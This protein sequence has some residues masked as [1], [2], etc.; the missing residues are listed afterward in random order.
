MDPETIAMGD[1]LFKLQCLIKTTEIQH[2][3]QCKL[4]RKLFFALATNNAEIILYYKR[5]SSCLP[6]VKK[7]P[8]FQGLHKQIAAFC[9]DSSGTWLLCVTLDGSLYVLPALTLVGENCIIDK[10]WKTDDA[11]YISFV[12]SQISHFRPI[13][14]IWWR[15]TKISEDIGIIGTECGAIIFINLSNGQ[16]LGITYI[17]ES[18]SNLHLC[19]NEYNEIVSLL[20]TSKFQQQWRLSLEH[21]SFNLLHNVE[22]EKPY[23]ELNLSGASHYNVEDSVPNKSKLKELKQ[24]SVEK[25][26]I[27]KQKIIDTKNQTLKESLQYHDAARNKE[28]DNGIPVNSEISQCKLGF[29]SPE[30]ISKDTFLSLQYDRENR[31]LYTC[32]H[33]VTNYITVHGPNL[34]MVPLSMHKVFKSCETVLLAHRLFF[35]T[36][37]NQYVIYIISDQLSETHVNKDYQ[38]NP[39]SIIGTFSF[40]NSKEVIRAVYKVTQFNNTVPRKVCEEIEN[41]L[42][43]NVKDIK[44]EPFSL[45]TCIIVTNRCVYE[46]VLRKSLLSIFMELVLKRNE[47]QE[48]GKLAM[49]FGWNGQHLLEYVGDLFLSNKEFSRAVASYKM[50]KCKLLKSVLKFASVGH[51][52]ELLS[53]L[54]HCLLTPLITEMPI[55][56]RIHLSNLCV[57]SF[58]EMTLRI[59]SEQS[60][61]IYKEFLYFLSTNTFYDEL[62]AINIAGQTYLWEVLHHLAIQRSLYSQMLDILIKAIQIFGTN[63]IHSKSYGLLICLSE[64][65]LMQSMLL[66]Y[67]LAKSHI[68]FV[69]NNLR[70]SHIFVLQRLVTLYDPTNP[71]L[72]PRLIQCKARHKMVSYDFRSNQ[73]DSIDSTDNIDQSD[74]LVEEI[75]ETFILVL[76]T[77]IH[78]KRLLNPNSKFTFLY[79]VQL[80]EFSKEYSEM[81][82]H[83]D[84]KRRSLSTGFSHV[85]LVRNGNIYTWGS[86][87]QGCLGTGSSVLRYGT[88]HA[89]CFFKS[90]KIEVFSVSCG[91]CHTLAVTNNGIY[92]WGS[93]QFGQLGLGKVLQ[94]SSPE[95]VTSLAQEI[96]VDAVAGQYH[97]VALTADGRIFTW[98]WGVHGQLGH[99][100]TDEKA[101][102]SLVKAL[103]GV[104]V[105][106]ISA[107]YAHTLALSID[108]VVY[109]FGC[110][111]LGQLGTGDNTKSSVP[112]KISLPDRITL[113]ST[114]YFHN[115]AVSI[116]NKLYIWGASPQVLRL[117]AQAQKKTRI[118]EQQDANEKRNKALGEL[119]K[120]P[121]NATNLNGKIK[122]EFF[123]KKDSV[124]T[125]SSH[126]ETFNIETQKKFETK[127][128]HLKDFDLIEENQT[129]LKPCVVD[130]SLVK[131]QINQISVGCHH[132][133]LITKDGSLYTWGRN[134]DGQIGNGTRREVLIPT[135]LYYNSACIFA[136]I[137]PRHNDFKRIQN[138]W[139]LDTDA[140]SNY[141]LANNG[142]VPENNGNISDSSIYVENAGINKERINPVIN[143]VGVACG[144][145]YT[146]TIQ[147][148]GTVLAWG[149]NSR[150]QLGRIPAKDARD[151]D[152]KLVLLKSSKRIVRL[153]NALHV[154]LDVPS[155]V[156]GISTPVI[157]YRSN[158]VFS[159]AGLV[160]PLSVI[161]KSPGELTLHYVLEYFYSLYNSANIMKKCIELENY[162]ACSK[163]AALENNVLAA[164]TYQLKMLHKLSLQSKNYSEISHETTES[165]IQISSQNHVDVM[166]DSMSSQNIQKNTELF[167][168]QVEK[169][170]IESLEN[171]VAQSW[172]KISTSRSLNNLQTLAQELNSFDCQGGS[173]ELYKTRKKDD[174]SN[175]NADHSNAEYNSNEDKQKW[176]K[177]FIFNENDLLLQHKNV[178]CNSVQNTTRSIF[179]KSMLIVN[180]NRCDENKEKT[181]LSDKMSSHSQK[182][183]II[184]ETMKALRFYLKSIN[185]ESNT[186]KCEILQSAIGFWIEHK[187]PIQCLEN[188]FLEHIHIVYYPLGLLLFC[189]DVIERYLNISK[190]GDEEKDWC[191]NNLFSIKFC[192]QVLSMLMQHI[193]EDDIMPEYIK[194]FS[195]LT[196]DSY[197]APLNGYPGANGNNNPEEMMEGTVNTILSEIEDSKLFAHVKDPDAVNHLLTTEEDNMIFTCGHHFPISQYEAD[198]IPSLETELL[199]SPSLIL[200]CTSQYLGNMLSRTSEPEIICP[201]CI[202]GAL[203]ATTAKDYD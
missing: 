27:L 184:N 6:V 177:D 89:I 77:L 142:N 176:I 172:T 73:C 144:Y 202:I 127:N 165:T 166:R 155:Q 36:D 168:T 37:I 162:Q 51:T 111:I 137:P 120:I 130:T 84:F 118:S 105:C 180:D 67:D 135:P 113:I 174:S 25:L 29:V 101:T 181:I 189:Q 39:E 57:L 108:G 122:E 58:I 126:T 23:N 54:T 19:E 31:Q 100:N 125:K 190:Y 148:G 199:T 28:N 170:L 143:A 30:P 75:I 152:D 153:P 45:D 32:Y 185:N 200:P 104:V 10:K 65:D 52:S 119:E 35:I 98:G 87:V 1:N 121:S 63:D 167:N 156:P 11:T 175:V 138:Q 9:F 201:L 18:I 90:M 17:N 8:W 112:I 24:L 78:K 12:N 194:I 169:N 117:Q 53:C 179:M 92:A 131:G 13:A 128:A 182:N 97:S 5:E 83:V 107:G 171:S 16:Q 191:A 129:H 69:R 15:N 22:N 4:E 74:T 195:S 33:L 106:C 50:S 159:L 109:A 48:A 134:L 38:F 132:N 178:T 62:L 94:C 71:V 193:D 197:G 187:L 115:L 145:D 146:V 96:I 61:A 160:Y 70:D 60:K 173:E 95:L 79:D 3:V 203:R 34:T 46:V 56:T 103:L 102:P 154:A 139:D 161:E 110:N 151:A 158:D 183:Y 147:P 72:R 88:P 7:I 2:S 85:A 99:G 14:I 114:G 186:V 20:I 163:I 40:K 136:Q 86:S 150:A 64:S 44:V 55:A 59:W 66:N 149:N 133:A 188:I 123:N 164:F 76:L 42:P 140:K 124:Q 68:L 91:H 21:M 116:T 41:T 93:S 81:T 47:L 198:V 157:S 49:I 80:P 141:S 26:T 192:L 43:K 82:M 196:A